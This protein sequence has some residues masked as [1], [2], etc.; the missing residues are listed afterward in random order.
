MQSTLHS[1]PSVQR[2]LGM[3]LE[4]SRRAEHRHDPVSG[5]LLDRAT[6]PLDLLHHGVVEALETDSNPLGILVAR[7]SSRADE[8]GEQNRDELA[9][10]SRGHERSLA[11]PGRPRY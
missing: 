5:E 1:E 11:E 6:R 2:P 4:R 9:F 8:I 3:I 10:L 7:K